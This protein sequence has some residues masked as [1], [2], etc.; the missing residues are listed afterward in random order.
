MFKQLQ[1]KIYTPEKFYKV[2]LKSEQG[3]LAF[4]NAYKKYALPGDIQ[5]FVNDIINSMQDW[6]F[7][8]LTDD[9]MNAADT[10]FLS[11]E[12]D[13]KQLIITSVQ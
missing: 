7:E 4:D 8:Q 2:F 12:P 5:L 6:L 10:L 9:E 11:I 3:K 13:L 1:D